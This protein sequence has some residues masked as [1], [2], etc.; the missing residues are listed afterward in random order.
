MQ[1][2]QKEKDGVVICNISGEINIDNADDLQKIFKKIILDKA[3]KVLLDFKSLDY[4]DSAGFACL[5]QFS[6]ELKEADA[7]LFLSGLS[8]KVGSL[9]AITKLENAFKIYDTEE[10]ALQDSCGY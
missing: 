2:K 4:I 8:P 6:R 1:V 9:F 3:R 10:D 5:I 7:V